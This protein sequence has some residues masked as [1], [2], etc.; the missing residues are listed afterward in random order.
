[1]QAQRF[2][3]RG[4]GGAEFVR[5]SDA[6]MRDVVLAAQHGRALRMLRAYEVFDDVDSAGGCWNVCI[7]SSCLPAP[8]LRSGNI[9]ATFQSFVSDDGVRATSCSG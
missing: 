3:E 5:L 4:I 8:G 2:R 6:D 9:P 7:L 1:M